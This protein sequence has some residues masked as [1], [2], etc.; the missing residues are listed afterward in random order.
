MKILE[1]NGHK[2]SSDTVAAIGFFDGVHT[3]HEKLIST[4]IDIA[5]ARQLKRA[6]ITFDVHPKSVLFELDYRYITPHHRKIEE[7]SKYQL[8]YLY[9]IR[10]DK[11]KAQ[12]SP[13]AFIDYY[14][15]GL[16]TLVCGFDFK[17]GVRASGNIHTL[18]ASDLFK[19][20][21]VEE[22]RFQGY[23]IGSTHIR[24]LIM[25]GQ[26]DAIEETLGRR[27]S[28][29]GEVI[30][31]QKKGREIGYPTANIDTDSYLIP[32][33]G[34]YVS[35]TKVKDR[36]YPSISTI[37]YNPTLNQYRGLSTESYILNFNEE[38]YG[39]IIEMVFVKRIRNE[40]TFPNKE[41]LIKQIKHD[42]SEALKII[43]NDDFSL[44]KI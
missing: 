30:H 31:G 15:N 38:I 44:H 19:T 24:D 28:I 9:V 22:M 16:N 34:V 40:M 36:W 29:K 32:R 33:Q 2:L 37:G 39:E 5:D 11:E 20:I 10:F 17:F 25:S 23:K 18:M 6:V 42:E 4:M 26:V 12:M 21:V 8:D 41:A 14:L 13:N 43:E 27:Y 1:L 35:Y 7:L 3:A